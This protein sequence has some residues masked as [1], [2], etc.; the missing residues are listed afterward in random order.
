MKLKLGV[1]SLSLALF[2][3]V[4]WGADQARINEAV[5]RGAKYLAGIAGQQGYAGGAHGSGSASLIG[6]ALLEAN[7]PMNDPSLLNIINTVRSAALTETKTYNVALSIVFLDRLG[8]PEDEL[9]IQ[10]LGIKLYSALTSTGGWTY[11][12]SLNLGG[13][14]GAVGAGPGFPAMQGFPGAPVGQPG[15]PGGPSG[16]PGA[17]GIPIGPG[18]MPVGPG[19][20]GGLPPIPGPGAPGGEQAQPPG[21]DNGFPKP[22]G[23]GPQPDNG[24]PQPNPKGKGKGPQPDNGFPQGPPKQNNNPED[25]STAKLKP[26]ALQVYLQV[27]NA[28][29]SGR[30]GGDGDNSNT[31]FGLIGLWIATRHGVPAND[32]LALIEARFMSTQN[33]VS[34]GWGYT[35]NDGSAT[36]SMT[37]AGLL[38]LAV[39]AGRSAPPPPPQPKATGNKPPS[40]D[41]FDNPKKKG[42]D[43]PDARRG[44]EG[45][46]KQSVD[47]GLIALGQVMRA[48]KAGTPLKQF[49]GL[50]DEYYLLWSIERVCMAYGLDTLGDVDWHDYGSNW[51]ISSQV[52]D[53]SWMGGH[54]GGDVNTAFAILFL[55]RSNFV[56]DLSAR[57]RGKITDPGK[58]ELRGSNVPPLFA[59]KS[60]KP[61][62]GESGKPAEPELPKNDPIADGLVAATGPVW[63]E[64]LKTVKESKGS[65]YT[66]GLVRAIPL[67]DANR[68][69]EAREALAER[70]TRMT[71]STLRKMMNDPNPELRRGAV[72]ACGMKEDLDHVVDLIERITDSS[73]LVV[74]A[75][76][77]SLKSLTSKDFGPPPNATDEAKDQA[78]AE[79]Q[80]W[81]KE[82][83]EKP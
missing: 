53:G 57:L 22:R 58:S 48:V 34:G 59:P 80:K 16:V 68:K 83:Q 9:A 40:D 26:E 77:A 5:V 30:Q 37:C 38:G 15:V 18:G 73:D 25:P 65:E 74:R 28:L 4:G 67:L 39:G 49:V 78:K 52:Q 56:K 72:L 62:S 50:G 24:F 70:L 61:S 36:G 79:W 45:I 20:P 11:D 81:F 60:D 82:Q 47:R 51:L 63:L 44:F 31:Q 27:R 35:S 43:V 8:M 2:A 71:A 6:L 54:H 69:K 66:A 46:R 19:M 7:V 1:A 17:P 42:G 32:A 55:T 33:R 21:P 64:K 23:K 14:G 29:R 12:C 41:P 76:R 75:T 10:L 3:S 13:L